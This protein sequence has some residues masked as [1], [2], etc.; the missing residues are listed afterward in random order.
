MRVKL[1][2]GQVRKKKESAGR[3]SRQKAVRFFAENEGAISDYAQQAGFTFEPGDHW[4]VD[5]KSCRGTYDTDY[6]VSR[7]YTVA[8]SMWATCHEIEHFRDWR[9]DP[10]AYDVLYRKAAS[11]RRLGLLYHY[12]NDIMV[13]REE[14]R[15]FPAH[16]ETRDYLYVT[17][18]LPRIDYTKAPRHIQFITTMLR[19]KVLPGECLTLS[20]EVRETLEKLKN[21]DGQGTDLIDLVTDPTALPR[22]RFLVIRDYIEPL[23]EGFFQEDLK[24]RKKEET[25]KTEKERGS[26]KEESMEGGSRQTLKG[27][28]ERDE[29]TDEDYFLREYD[30]SEKLFPQVL[31]PNEARDEIEQEIQRRKEEGKAPDLMAREQFKSLYGVSAEE[32]EDYSDDYKKIE[33]SI[34]PLRGIFERVIASRKETKRRLKERTDQGVVIDPSMLSQAYIDIQSGIVNSRTQLKVCRE[35]FDEHLLR[36]FEFT[37]VCDLS[38]S[39]NENW[40]GGKSYEQRLSTILVIEALDEFEKQLKIERQSGFIDLHI[41]TEVRGFYGDDVELKPLGDS[42]D[43]CRRVSISRRLEDCTGN[44]TTDYKSLAEV[45]AKISPSTEKRIERG[46]LRKVLLLLTDG[47]SDDVALARAARNELNKKG[48]ISRAIQIG[49]QRREETEKFKYVWQ[50]EGTHCR[51]VSRL[52]RAINKL[53]EGFLQNL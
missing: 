45:A 25:Q 11:E 13:N 41:F 42:I 30:E 12:L 20:V 49:Q 34:D 5:M 19:E 48:V 24:K 15:R 22:E 50:R 17:K 37:L 7:G 3:K 47:G 18:L 35:E 32:M 27:Y 36:D 43:F 9:K 1:K 23:Y 8:E 6:F 29:V 44:S 53:L 33:G 2:A 21:I 14:D 16:R 4:S 40:P 31:S 51:N 28:M 26:L 39:M 38:G 10:E 52:V 46:E